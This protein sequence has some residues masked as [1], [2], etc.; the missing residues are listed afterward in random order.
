VLETARS[1]AAALRRCSCGPTSAA[2]TARQRAQV[3]AQSEGRRRRAAQ[4]HSRD[5]DSRAVVLL[6]A[7]A[8]VEAVW[9]AA[10]AACQRA[11]QRS[12]VQSRC[13]AEIPYRRLLRQIRADA[14]LTQEA[15][16]KRLRR[17]RTYVAKSE[18]GER[19][20]DITELLPYCRAC[21]VE[22][23]EFCENSIIERF[24]ANR[25]GR[26]SDVSHD[27]SV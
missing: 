16:A 21:G 4:S 12:S 27:C 2:T 15:L 14:G 19:R 13:S 8:V 1:P 20:L 25:K 9:L 26:D 7:T 3:P 24:R 18:L 10:L 5:Y 6:F 17:P 22:P 11:D 23:H